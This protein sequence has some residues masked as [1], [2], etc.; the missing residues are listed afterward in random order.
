M[1]IDGQFLFEHIAA[2]SLWN[3]LTDPDQIAQCLPGCEK[4][5]QNGD[6]SYQMTLKIGVGP[7]QGTFSGAVRL[8]NLNPVSD[9]RMA[10]SGSGTHGF[11]QGEGKITLD[12]AGDG[13]QLS[14]AGDVTAGGAIA[15]VG[16]RM[17][18]GAARLVIDKFFKCAATK[19][20]DKS[21]QNETIR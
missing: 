5:V 11:V 7:I 13:T 6:A 1:R 9:F 15:T 18:G 4:L 21:E 20:T 17:I 14:Y 8:D 19:L 12:V 2:V 16:Q 10:V 3:F